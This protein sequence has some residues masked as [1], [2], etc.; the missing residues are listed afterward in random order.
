MLEENDE[1]R[2]ERQALLGVLSL[3][4]EFA[5]HRDETSRI[6]AQKQLETHSLLQRFKRFG[7][8]LCFLFVLIAAAYLAGLQ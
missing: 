8:F 6:Q 1:V 3:E 2:G 4:A 7:L 5:D